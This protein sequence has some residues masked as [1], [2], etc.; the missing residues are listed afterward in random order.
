MASLIRLVFS[1][2]DGSRDSHAIREDLFSDSSPLRMRAQPCRS[3]LARHLLAGDADWML[4]RALFLRDN[5]RMDQH[6]YLFM[7]GSNGAPFGSTAPFIDCGDWIF[8]ESR[9]DWTGLCRDDAERVIE[10]SLFSFWLIQALT[11]H[12]QARPP[13]PQP[14]RRDDSGVKLPQ[15]AWAN[16]DWNWLNHSSERLSLFEASFKL[17]LDPSNATAFEHAATLSHPRIALAFSATS[18]K[19]FASLA[20]GDHALKSLLERHALDH[21]LPPSPRSLG[22]ARL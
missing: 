7:D 1:N 10:S 3:L 12:A 18:P 16:L 19:A 21:L 8:H 2:T 5:A 14:I 6:E 13:S 11:V 4:S 20:G 15:P 22:V 9:K 17:S